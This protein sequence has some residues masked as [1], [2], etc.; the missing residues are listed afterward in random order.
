MHVSEVEGD[1]VLFFKFG[2][3][4]DLK[5]LYEQVARTFREFHERLAAYEIRRFCQ[6][7]ACVSASKLTLKIVTHYGEFTSYNVRNFEKLIGRDVIV[8]HQL[9]K[10]DIGQQEYWLVTPDLLPKADTPDLPSWIR[11]SEGV[12]QTESGSIAF[13]YAPLSELRQAVS[14]RPLLHAELA[15]KTKLLSASREYDAHIIT[16]FHATG[17]FTYRSRWQEGVQSVEEV[18]HYL[19]R[20][21]MRCRHVMEDGQSTVYATSYS[22]RPDRIQFSE[23]D[24]DRSTATYFTL[25]AI[26]PYRT[27]LTVDVYVKKGFARELLLR[28]TKRSEMEA[29]LQRSLANLETVAAEVTVPV[30]Y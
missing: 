5:E 23:T 21:G 15:Q 10:N 6:C 3:T 16:M 18:S 19:P 14:P 22:F 2:D 4:P 13:H 28:L 30:E 17:N 9:L 1:A 24:E 27:R 26:E 7:K 8:A 29:A 25:E 20:V 11:W 12:K